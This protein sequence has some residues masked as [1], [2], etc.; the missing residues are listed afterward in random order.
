MGL[1][2]KVAALMIAS[3]LHI[4]EGAAMANIIMIALIAISVA[5]TCYGGMRSVIATDLFQFVVLSVGLVAVVVFLHGVIP[6]DQAIATVQAKKG[7]GG[8]AL[9][10]RA[11]RREQHDTGDTRDPTSCTAGGRVGTHAL[12]VRRVTTDVLSAEPA[13]RMAADHPCHCWCLHYSGGPGPAD[14]RPCCHRRSGT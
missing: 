11:C 14:T 13:V 12:D 8:L 3:L 4:G 7:A 6:F 5:Y 9:E 1:F 2:L 10:L